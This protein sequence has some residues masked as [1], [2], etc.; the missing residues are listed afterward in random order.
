MSD[1]IEF[2]KKFRVEEL[3]I[4]EFKHWTWSLRPVQITL[5]SSILA[6]KSEANALNFVADEAWSEMKKISHAI[7]TCFKEKIHAE[8]SNYLALMMVDPHVHFH[9]LPR[10]S[11][12]RTLE[13][14]SFEDRGW[15]ALP[16]FAAE[17]SSSEDLKKICA[18]L[19]A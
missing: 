14:I 4:K 1:L 15:P 13:G 10:Y 11:G 7:E 8:K 16:N 19:K 3:L 17:P 2:R 18:W 6:L 9:V 12:I 5:G